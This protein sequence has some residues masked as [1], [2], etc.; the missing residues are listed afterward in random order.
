M[1]IKL[2]KRR[3]A[4]KR[5]L[6]RSFDFR[7]ERASLLK[8][9]VLI[10]LV[11]NVFPIAGVVFWGWDVFL[12]LVLFWM[13]NLI[14][15]FYTAVKLLL[16]SGNNASW[17]TKASTTLFFCFHYGLFTLVHGAFVFVVFGGDILNESSSVEVA[18]IWQKTI[19][20]QLGWGGLALFISHG[21]SFFNNYVGAGEYKQSSLNDVMQQPYG[22][23]VI[24]HLTIIFGGFLVTLIG[25]PVAGL[26]LLVIFKTVMDVRAHL[27]QHDKYTLQESATT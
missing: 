24:L 2:R 18:S 3:H 21:V 23:V 6:I 1:T 14:I 13:E 7:F 27:L 16:V 25:S 11:A 22:R 20:H 19:S 26:V 5:G 17:S 4:L 12:L 9:S 8:P 15:G 10:L